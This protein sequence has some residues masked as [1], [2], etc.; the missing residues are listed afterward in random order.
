MMLGWSTSYFA[1]GEIN[2][3]I[4]VK[5]VITEQTKMTNES[6]IQIFGVGYIDHAP[7][8]YGRVRHSK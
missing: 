1:S 5:I 2:D 4:E 6:L 7:I 8:S 3:L